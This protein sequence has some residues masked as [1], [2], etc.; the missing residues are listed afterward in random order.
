MGRVSMWYDT[1]MARSPLRIAARALAVALMVLFVL[2]LTG[3]ASMAVALSCPSSL[4][5]SS[6]R[7]TGIVTEVSD[8]GHT[9]TVRTDDGRIVT[10]L[11]GDPKTATP[12]DRIFD[13]ELRYEFHPLN[14]TTPYRDN[15]CTAT[16]ALGPASTPA[17][18][19]VNTRGSAVNTAA[20]TASSDGASEAAS[21]REHAWP[22]GWLSFG[23]I[24]LALATAVLITPRLRQPREY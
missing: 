14:D 5:E 1:V 18:A 17:V 19:P 9:A 13:K 11:G 7:F 4:R 12:D 15:A 22:G 8:G 2:P 21:D 10:V 16:R 6:H 20:G 3:S 23:A 24:I